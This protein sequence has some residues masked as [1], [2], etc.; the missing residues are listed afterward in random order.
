MGNHTLIRGTQPFKL[1]LKPLILP[2][3]LKK[4]SERGINCEGNLVTG[5]KQQTVLYVKGVM[6]N[7]HATCF[8]GNI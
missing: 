6:F 4:G 2:H 1:S 8:H 3:R 7:D 5:N